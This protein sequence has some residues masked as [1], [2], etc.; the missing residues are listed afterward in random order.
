L[1]ADRADARQFSAQHARPS[2]VVDAFRRHGR[3]SYDPDQLYRPA[4]N[5]AASGN[6]GEPFGRAH[7]IVDL[8]CN[9]REWARDNLH[10]APVPTASHLPIFDGWRGAT[11][12]QSDQLS[13]GRG[14]WR[15]YR[16][17]VGHYVTWRQWMV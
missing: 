6:I 14:G 4:V 11:G 2:P 8:G 7:G 5:R 9:G 10:V 15:I 3:F 12:D 16:M 13:A 17:R 1:P